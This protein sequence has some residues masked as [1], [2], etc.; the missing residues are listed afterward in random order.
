[1]EGH[2]YFTDALKHQMQ[3]DRKCLAQYSSEERHEYSGGP[4]FETLPG[5][6]LS[7]V[8]VLVVFLNSQKKMTEKCVKMAVIASFHVII[9]ALQNQV[10]LH[11]LSS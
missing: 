8:T 11:N 9:I 1:M 7:S 2:V 5:N 4:A 3:Q 6:Q 10:I